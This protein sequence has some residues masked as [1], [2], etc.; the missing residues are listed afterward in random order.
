MFVDNDDNQSLI[1][2]TTESSE[3]NS[4]NQP[5]QNGT[6]SKEHQGDHKENDELFTESETK[7]GQFHSHDNGRFSRRKMDKPR[8][9]RRESDI[10]YCDTEIST[11]FCEKRNSVIDD[12]LEFDLESLCQRKVERNI[13]SEKRRELSPFITHDCSPLSVTPPGPEDLSLNSCNVNTNQFTASS[14]HT[15]LSPI[16][17]RSGLKNTA[18]K[19]SVSISSV[20]DLEKVVNKHL[21]N[22]NQNTRMGTS[23]NQST[24]KPRS[25]EHWQSSSNP[26]ESDNG[27]LHPASNLLRTLYAN[28]ESV[29]RSSV[30][31]TSCINS[32]DSECANDIDMLPSGQNAALHESVALSIPV[33]NISKTRSSTTSSYNGQSEKTVYNNQPE[34]NI[35]PPSSVSPKDKMES[36]Y[37]TPGDGDFDVRMSQPCQEQLCHTNIISPIDVKT[38]AF[39]Q[40]MSQH[41]MN[42]ELNTSVNKLFNNNMTSSYPPIP[43][44]Q[45]HIHNGNP[46]VVYDKRSDAWYPISYSP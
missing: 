46:V 32:V 39:N 45:Q 31:R 33:L 11:S 16:Q 41:I 7:Q 26:R 42:S 6:E 23:T 34:Y 38:L 25:T 43:P 3:D 19:P 5:I 15:T 21:S 37:T 24:V 30:T 12:G 4:T 22:G 1:N 28:R 40:A 9:R 29:I 14:N 27:D 18:H 36:P 44:Y 17:H 20:K 10:E 8:K 35:T 2:S 13:T